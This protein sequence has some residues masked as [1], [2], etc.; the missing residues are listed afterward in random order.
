MAL[1]KQSYLFVSQFATTVF[2]QVVK[3][4]SVFAK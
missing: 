3:I 4:Y 1:S 2:Y